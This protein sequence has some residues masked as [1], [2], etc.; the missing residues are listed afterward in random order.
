MYVMN[1]PRARTCAHTFVAC[2]ASLELSSAAFLVPLNQLCKGWGKG[3]AILSARR[4][5][6]EPSSTSSKLQ[7]SPSLTLNAQAVRA[8]RQAHSYPGAQMNQTR[9]VTQVLNNRH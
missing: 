3:S 6:Y 8:G 9:N 7:S 1:H 4:P 5:D 2:A